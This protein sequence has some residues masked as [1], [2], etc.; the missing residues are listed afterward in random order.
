[1]ERQRQTHRYLVA[2]RLTLICALPFE[3]KPFLSNSS[4]KVA[5]FPFELYQTE[6][7][8]VLVTGIG[9]MSVSAALGWLFAKDTTSRK[10]LNIGIAASTALPLYSWN[11]VVKLKYHP[12]LY[13]DIFPTVISN[14]NLPY[15]TLQTVD[16]PVS[17]NQMRDITEDLVD[18]EGY[19]IGFILKKF[20]K[21][22]YYQILK[23]VSDTGVDKINF[24]DVKQKYHQH[25][26]QVFP[27]IHHWRDLVIQPDDKPFL[28][29]FEM[30]TTKLKLT[31]TEKEQLE[32]AL[33][34][35][36]GY[37]KHDALKKINQLIGNEEFPHK[38]DNQRIFKHIITILST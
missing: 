10:F 29:L 11:Y 15:A 27:F 8:D 34:F 18:M 35:A 17:S 28:T 13:K 2:E 21:A 22:S 33:R 38:R 16:V 24:D 3:A 37:E 19:A 20:K 23:W 7:W 25:V 26:E 6:E 5:S 32:K 1:M 36:L 31:F 14:K 30:I 12:L 9:G 4:K